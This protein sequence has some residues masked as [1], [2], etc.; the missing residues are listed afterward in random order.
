[1]V[2]NVLIP[3]DYNNPRDG[4][5]GQCGDCGGSSETTGAE[6][7]PTGFQRHL[8]SPGLSVLRSIDFTR[9]PDPVRTA[10]SDASAG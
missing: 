7:N 3:G 9:Y 1:M 10:Q 8:Q 2:I 4:T 6:K 5:S